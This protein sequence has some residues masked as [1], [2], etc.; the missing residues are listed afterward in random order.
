M[1][2]EIKDQE[3]PLLYKFSLPDKVDYG[4][5]YVYD[6]NFE[7]PV[8]NRKCTD[9]ACLIVFISF[10]CGWGVI[11]FYGFGQGDFNK[12]KLHIQCAICGKNSL[13]L[14]EISRNKQIK[15]FSKEKNCHEL[16]FWSTSKASAWN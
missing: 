8:K 6:L 15:F 1:T 11:A 16:A 2:F 14:I 4:A 3:I 5:P 12:V 10:L 7:G 9:V 13:F